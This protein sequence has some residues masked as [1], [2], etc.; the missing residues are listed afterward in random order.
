LAH[1]ATKVSSFG[2]SF[3]PLGGIAA[4]PGSWFTAIN[5]LPVL[6]APFQPFALSRRR[7]ADAFG[8]LWQALHFAA[9]SGRM[10]CS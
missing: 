8:P 2:D 7:P 3:P 6:I 10:F 1:S 5:S 9:K 4:A